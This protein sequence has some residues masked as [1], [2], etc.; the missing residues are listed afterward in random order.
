MDHF[1]TILMSKRSKKVRKPRPRSRLPSGSVFTSVDVISLDFNS[2][3]IVGHNGDQTTVNEESAAEPDPFG[4]EDVCHECKQ[5]YLSGMSIT[6]LDETEVLDTGICIGSLAHI[7]PTG[8]CGMCRKLFDMRWSD[9]A[10]NQYHLHAFSAAW[11]V[12]GR[13]IRN[14][15]ASNVSKMKRTIKDTALFA[16]TADESN[17]VSV[18]T[19]SENSRE[20]TFL[21]AC[22]TDSIGQL[23][24]PPLVEEKESDQDDWDNSR[25]LSQTIG[26]R[27][28]YSPTLIEAALHQVGHTGFINEFKSPNRWELSSRYCTSTSWD[29]FIT[30][31]IY[32]GNKNHSKLDI[33]SVIVHADESATLQDPVILAPSVQSLHSETFH[34]RALD[35]GKIDYSLLRGWIKQCQTRCDGQLQNFTRERK[36]FQ[37]IQ[38]C[39]LDC[40]RREVFKV[41]LKRNHRYVALSYVWG[42]TKMSIRSQ[43]TQL[44]FAVMRRCP[45]TIENAITVVLE[46]GY[47]YL[48][49]DSLCISSEKSLRHEQIANM[50]V[51][52]KNA[53]LTIIAA[54]GDN[55]EYGLPGVSNRQRSQQTQIKIGKH[56]YVSTTIQPS[57]FLNTSTY[58]T[59]AWT[60]Q[61]F[62][63][64]RR[65]LIFSDDQ[66]SFECRAFCS[67]H[68]Q[69]ESL[70][71][72][73]GDL[74]CEKKDLTQ[75]EHD[76]KDA[77]FRKLPA[78][79]KDVLY[80]TDGA[81]GDCQ[82]SCVD[83][84]FALVNFE[85]HVS[86]FTK[87]KLS[88]DVDSLQA[89]SSILDR[90]AY[91]GHSIYHLHGIPYIPQ[92]RTGYLEG[93]QR[94]AFTF[95]Y[96]LLWTHGPRSTPIRRRPMFPSW[97]WTGWEGQVNWLPDTTN[98]KRFR[99]STKYAARFEF[100]DFT[101][102]KR[103]V[104]TAVEDWRPHPQSTSQPEALVFT[105]KL[106]EMSFQVCDEACVDESNIYLRT[107]LNCKSRLHVTQ[108]DADPAAVTQKTFY[109]ILL[110]LNKE[111]SLNYILVV[112]EIASRSTGFGGRY[113]E[114]VGVIIVS[115]N[116]RYLGAP[117]VVQGWLV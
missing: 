60:Y 76:L 84:V 114:R 13:S 73:S 44:P 34:G 7:S 6:T 77:Y 38:F 23:L 104:L 110:G 1:T 100:L 85:H 8:S 42:N 79:A 51:I 97:T 56:H 41:P 20:N 94:H 98:I 24:V 113:Y 66:V 46:L 57:Y 50:D 103:G 68:H 116:G 112:Q 33:G 72:P 16:V 96:G 32:D 108:I 101:E 107:E 67:A 83:K 17:H 109:G 5:L 55:A 69:Q 59:R 58:Q 91:E 62:F 102:S 19:A 45:K 74:P 39:L 3:T 22:N 61:E 115:R 48:W 31:D 117:S 111:S 21:I 47:R 15:R 82:M 78:Q 53:E 27:K 37:K 52:Y 70:G 18:S 54:A 88:F 4:F 93:G 25:C 14:L 36:R 87:R 80:G 63:F 10:T 75:L 28:Q 26:D 11:M 106:Y 35:P 30:R 49:I 105:A 64:S 65:R 89:V 9:S 86:Q 40:Q 99:E 2:L 43:A 71:C 81:T 90:F 92:K 12:Y 95:K 29:H